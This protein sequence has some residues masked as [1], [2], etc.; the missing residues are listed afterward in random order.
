M[1][2]CPVTVCGQQLFN[3]KPFTST[4]VDLNVPNKGVLISQ[5]ALKGTTDQ[6]TIPTGIGLHI[7]NTATTTGI[8]A[9]TPGLYSWNGDNWIRSN[10]QP[11][12]KSNRGNINITSS[13]FVGRSDDTDDVSKNIGNPSGLMTKN[14]SNNPICCDSS[15]NTKTGKNA[16][17][18]S[19]QQYNH[20][21]TLQK[22]IQLQQLQIDELNKRVQILAKEQIESDNN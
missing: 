17:P 3:Q 6:N 2:N 11:E 21:D 13:H 10:Y 22:Q 16:H 7:Y 1:A 8:D 5:V 4:M 20:N 18:V 14:E 15:Y 12:I 19:N 9:I